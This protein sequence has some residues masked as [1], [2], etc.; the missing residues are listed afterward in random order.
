MWPATPDFPLGGSASRPCR[1][2]DDAVEPTNRRPRLP[3]GTAPLIQAFLELN[4][5]RARP[6]PPLTARELER[7]TELRWQ[8][9]ALLVDSAQV[10]DRVRRALRVPT[11]LPVR[12]SDPHSDQLSSARE[13]AEG[14]LFLATHHPAAVGTPLQLRIQGDD[15]DAIE[16]KGVVAWVRADASERGPAGMGIRFETLEPEQFEGIAELVQQALA[17]L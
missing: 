3:P 10:G 8:L 14:G 15:G 1:P 6:N 13:I 17:A 9:E 7:W 4:R 16:V 11:D 12:V 5:R 2:I